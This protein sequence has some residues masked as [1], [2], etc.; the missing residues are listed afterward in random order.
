MRVATL[1]AGVA[2]PSITRAKLFNNQ[3]HPTTNNYQI[4]T[5]KLQP[6]QYFW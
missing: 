1:E 4:T 5:I 3:Y 2:T 6:W